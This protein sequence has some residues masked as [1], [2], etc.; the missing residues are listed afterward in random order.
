[1]TC[2]YHNAKELRFSDTITTPSGQIEINFRFGDIAPSFWKL[3]KRLD[4]R[5][6]ADRQDALS[7]LWR[8]I[9]PL[10]PLCELEDHAEEMLESFA[11]YIDAKIMPFMKAVSTALAIEYCATVHSGLAEKIRNYVRYRFY[12]WKAKRIGGGKK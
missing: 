8:L 5:D 11:R 6:A 4:N 10:Y 3:K 2:D 12:C 7:A 1:M 9:I